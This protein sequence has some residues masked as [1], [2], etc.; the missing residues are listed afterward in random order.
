MRLSFLPILFILFSTVCA[1]PVP[2]EDHGDHS[3]ALNAV[4]PEFSSITNDPEVLAKLREEVKHKECTPA[5]AKW[6]LDKWDPKPVGL[7]PGSTRAPTVMG[8]EDVWVEHV[9]EKSLRPHQLEEFVLRLEKEKQLKEWR[10]GAFINPA[11]IVYHN[12]PAGPGGT[13]A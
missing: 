7:L 3:A 1:I 11:V 10:S 13:G 9:K 12:S 5:R 2:A 8:G 4:P 6:L